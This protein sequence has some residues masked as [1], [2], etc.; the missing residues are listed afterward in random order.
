MAAAA[1]VAAL[2][3]AEEFV[4]AEGAAD[5]MVEAVLIAELELLLCLCLCC[6]V[7]GPGDVLRLLDTLFAPFLEVLE[8]L[9]LLWVFCLFF[10]F[11][12]WLLPL[13]LLLSDSMVTLPALLLLLLDM[14]YALEGLDW[15]TD[16]G[17]GGLVRSTIG[18]DCVPWAGDV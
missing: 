12:D 17:G 15:G 10:C 9:V 7:V 2:D 16:K 8:P 3:G 18:Q 1:E 4:A 6:L 5:V 14:P 13:M 11:F